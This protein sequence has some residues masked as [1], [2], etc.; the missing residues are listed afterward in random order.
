MPKTYTI[1]QIRLLDTQKSLKRNL[2]K[3]DFITV[4]SEMVSQIEEI[5]RSNTI[6]FVSLP[7]AFGVYLITI[8]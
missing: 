3:G 8:N 5:L 4:G 2:K 7:S 6:Q 1:D